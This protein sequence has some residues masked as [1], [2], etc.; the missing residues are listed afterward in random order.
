MG[1]QGEIPAVCQLILLRG[2]ITNFTAQAASI[3][4]TIGTVLWCVQ[5]VPQ[6]WYNWH[7]KS[8]DGLPGTMLF[9]W[10]AG[11]RGQRGVHHQLC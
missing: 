10:A 9:L 6:I 4:G 5:I 11:E 8:T 1:P 7:R 2:S 3:L